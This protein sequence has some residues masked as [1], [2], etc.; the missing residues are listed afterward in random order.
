MMTIASE[1][2]GMKVLVFYERRCKASFYLQKVARSDKY[3]RP[4]DSAHSASSAQ[5]F[6]SSLDRR[7][8]QTSNVLKA[9]IW[10]TAE[11]FHWN[12]CTSMYYARFS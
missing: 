5:V 8:L 10:R 3:K 9:F 7:M 11:M 12:R 2:S 6:V 1:T 4:W